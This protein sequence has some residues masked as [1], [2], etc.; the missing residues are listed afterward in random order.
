MFSWS[1]GTQYWNLN[2]IL[3]GVKLCFRFN[4]VLGFILVLLIKL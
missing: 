4:L 3:D 1:H 2:S